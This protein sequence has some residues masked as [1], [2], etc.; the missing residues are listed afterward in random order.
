MRAHQAYQSEPPTIRDR[1]PTSETIE[2]E[3][4]DILEATP[5]SPAP[6]ATIQ[7][8]SLRDPLPVLSVKLQDLTA[9]RSTWEAAGTCATAL[10]RVLLARAVIVHLY[11]QGLSELR[12]IGVQCRK[13]NDLLG[14]TEPL[15]D[16]LF[17]SAVVTNGKPVQVAFEG[18]P[19]R[20]IPERIRRLDAT[21]SLTAV[22]VMVDH[23]CVAIIEVVD[24]DE[25]FEQRALIACMF[26]ADRLAH[27]FARQRAKR[28]GE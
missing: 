18:L 7:G 11:D 25:R 16:D 10:V 1:T 8:K 5:T 19:P 22:P 14:A 23:E 3:D 9:A 26:A 2:L 12:I 27:C 20:M 28:G 17:A 4:D 13:A 6:G 21:S 15:S 24:L